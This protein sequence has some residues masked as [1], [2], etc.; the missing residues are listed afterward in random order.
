MVVI[1]VYNENSSEVTVVEVASWDG[2]VRQWKPY[3]LQV[4]ETP[5]VKKKFL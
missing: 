1:K 2:Q 4:I 5:K 3:H